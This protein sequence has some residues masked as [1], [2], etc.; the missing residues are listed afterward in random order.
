LSAAGT[1][2]GLLQPWTRGTLTSEQ[3]VGEIAR[4]TG[5][6]YHLALDGLIDSCRAMVVPEAALDTVAALRAQGTKVVI[7]TDNMDT[8]WR[9]TI[10]SLGLARRFDAI[11][12]SAALGAHKWEVDA[13]DRSA[14]FQPF[15]DRECIGPGESILLDD[16]AEAEELVKRFG[17]DYWQI[18]SPEELTTVLAALSGPLP[19]PLTTVTATSAPH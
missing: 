3:V 15:L 16:S 1:H 5:I 4:A 12:S 11:L 13:A 10:P 6:D 14:F 19:K 7:A 2:A 9:W 17:I 8:F 18:A